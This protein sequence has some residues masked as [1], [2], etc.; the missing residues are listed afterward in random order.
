MVPCLHI[1]LLK[2][3]A[4]LLA[5]LREER[6]QRHRQRDHQEHLAHE[7]RREDAVSDRLA[8]GTGKE[9]GYSWPY[10]A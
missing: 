9:M 2:Q 1:A 10:L 4:E 7:R 8:W 3:L 5:K 6:R